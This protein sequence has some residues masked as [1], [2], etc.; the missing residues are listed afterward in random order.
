MCGSDML[1][2]WAAYSKKACLLCE[3]FLQVSPQKFRIRGRHGG[4]YP[5]WGLSEAHIKPL[6]STLGHLSQ[7]LKHRIVE[8]LTT[9]P[10]TRGQAVPQSTIVSDFN[11]LDLKGI[12]DLENARRPWQSEATK[13]RKSEVHTVLYT[14]GLNRLDPFIALS[15]LARRGK[16]CLC[17]FAT[18]ILEHPSR[19]LSQRSIY[20]RCMYRS[21][22]RCAGE[23]ALG[24]ILATC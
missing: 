21:S 1:Q 23:R 3:A 9:G 22:T 16:A 14:M 13:K 7:F 8:L 24:W 11:S 17:I 10:S 19:F 2:N 20:P 5:A 6:F 4:C 18:F 15:I 12:K